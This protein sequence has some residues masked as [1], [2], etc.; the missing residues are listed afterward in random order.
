MEAKTER[1]NTYIN[2]LIDIVDIKDSNID[3]N[4]LE[5]IENARIKQTLEAIYAVI[6]SVPKERLV[7]FY[8]RDTRCL[9]D[10]NDVDALDIDILLNYSVLGVLNIFKNKNL[11][12][13]RHY[14]DRVLFQSNSN[15]HDHL[16]ISTAYLYN[17]AIDKLIDGKQSHISTI[18]KTNQPN[19]DLLKDVEENFVYYKKFE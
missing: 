11:S 2:S 1:L 14:H 16:I 17:D 9:N 12:S 7:Y 6:N 8:N 18:F 13:L 15:Y 3:I 4:Y 19:Y 10:F 5:E